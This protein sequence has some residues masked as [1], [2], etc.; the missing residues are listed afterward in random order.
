MTS[1]TTSAP[2]PP[3]ASLDR[4][5]EVLLAVVHRDIGTEGEACVHLA[6]RAARDDGAST[7]QPGQLDRHR[8]DAGASPVHEERL[9]LC[10]SG[11]AHD[12]RPDGAHR[13]GQ[14]RRLDQA[15]PRRDGHQLADRHRHLLGV[16]AAGEQGRHLVADLPALAP[17]HP[18]RRSAP[19]TPARGP[20]RR[21]P[22]VGRAPDAAGGP[23]G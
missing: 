6:R 8:A 12:V 18:G 20:T 13:L 17:V 5:D 16:A 14:G 3:V 23:P 21:R 9:T 11:H 15:Q 19:S 1:R 2:R 10:Q 4:G 22:E 7:D